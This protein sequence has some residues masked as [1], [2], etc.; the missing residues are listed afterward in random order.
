MLIAKVKAGVDVRVLTPGG[1]HHDVGPV[2][3]G[4]LAIYERLL[5]HGVRIFEYQVSMMHSKTLLVD[6]ELSMVGSTNLDPLAL[7]AEEGSLVV[8]DARMAGR[9]A[10]A[11]EEDLKHS[12]EVRWDSWRRRGLFKRLSERVTILFGEYL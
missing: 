3:A 2:L 1:R 8:D 5:E 12:V 10:Q 4:Q 6:D 11:F 9:L 7:S